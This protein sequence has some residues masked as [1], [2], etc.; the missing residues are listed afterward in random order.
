ML[1]VGAFSG[2][3]LAE[4][5]ADELQKMIEGSALL[6]AFLCFVYGRYF[7]GFLRF[8]FFFFPWF[9]FFHKFFSVVF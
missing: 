4:V 8:F 5:H 3:V 2:E 9:L 7:E 6:G 1:C